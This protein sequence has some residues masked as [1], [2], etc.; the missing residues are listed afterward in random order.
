MLNKLVFAD[1]HL[2][3]NPLRGIGAKVIAEKFK[4]I[5]G[6]FVVLVSLSPTH[7]GLEGFTF[8]D[9]T[10]SIDI[11]VKECEYAKEQG[12]KVICL[13]GIHPADVEKKVI[14]DKHKI[15]DTIILAKKIVEH[16]A[17]LIEKGVLDGFGEVGRPHYRTIPEAVVANEI[18]MRYVLTLARDLNAYV[19]LHL[20]QG[21]YATIEDMYEILKFTNADINK[22]VFHHLDLFTAIE[23]THKRLIFT[24]P[25]KYELLKEVIKR[26]DPIYIIESDFID[27]PKR[28]GVS[29]YPW[30]IAENQLKI[31]KEYN[32][33]EEY[34]YAINVDN[35]VRV[36]NLHPP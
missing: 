20:E 25:G 4:K 28:P 33:D 2:H 3:S 1:G 14:A 13:A 19:H 34:I 30:T 31:I 6:W 27:D 32:I 9:Y 36:Y 16:V 26:L 8:E 18:V 17:K 5:G 22:I 35:I 11:H 29:S 23:A 24:V 21:G 7:Y 12:I 15:G 10:K